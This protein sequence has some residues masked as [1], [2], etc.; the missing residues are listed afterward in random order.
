MRVSYTKF[1]FQDPNTEF[2]MLAFEE[3]ET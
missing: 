2:I 1:A 3:L